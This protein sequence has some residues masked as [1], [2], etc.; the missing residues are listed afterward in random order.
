MDPRE[1]RRTES[2]PDTC[3]QMEP[4]VVRPARCSPGA[5]GRLMPSRSPM[6]PDPTFPEPKVRPRPRQWGP[7]AQMGAA[8]FDPGRLRLGPAKARFQSFEQHRN[9]EPLI[10]QSGKMISAGHHPFGRAG[11]DCPVNAQP[12]SMLARGSLAP[13]TASSQKPGHTSARP[14][15]ISAVSST[16]SG[17]SRCGRRDPM[18]PRSRGG[19]QAWN[20]AVPAWRNAIERPIASSGSVREM[21]SG[22]V[23]SNENTP[24]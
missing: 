24:W 16:R 12:R 21:M 17:S 20:P 3:G 23:H 2:P 10:R 14:A 5:S 13:E 6:S 8:K 1:E 11:P 7:E 9:A 15:A 18:T 22:A 19:S 4:A